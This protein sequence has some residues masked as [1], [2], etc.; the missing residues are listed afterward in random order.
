MPRTLIVIV[1]SALLAVTSIGSWPAAKADAAGVGST[2][3]LPNITRM[4]GGADGWQTPFIVQNVGS[5][6]TD[7]TMDFFAFSDGRLVKTRTIPAVMPGTSVFHDPNSDT[8][9]PQGGQFSVVVRSSSSPI[10]SVV[11]E[12]QNVT[13]TSRQEA[14]SYLGISSGSTRVFLPY[15]AKNAGGWLTT[16]IIQNLGVAPANVTAQFRSVDGTQT[17][18]VSR[19]IGPGRSQFVDPTVEPSV[20]AGVEYS[21]ALVSDQPIGVVV[22]AHNDAAG[23]VAPKGFSYN[24]V[25]APSGDNAFMPYVQ[26]NVNGGT[27][28]LAVQNAG[29]GPTT[30]Q[31]RF[32]LA[33][34]FATPIVVTG[35]QLA[36]GAMWVYDPATNA[37]IADGEYGVTVAGGL[38]AVVGA[39]FSATSAAGTTSTDVRSAKLYFPNVTKTLGGANGWTTPL[40][41]QSTGAH[42]ATLKWYRFSDGSLAYSQTLIFNEYAQTFRIDPRQIPDLPDNSQYAVVATAGLGGYG[43]I[44][45]LVT[46]MN[47]SGGDGWMTYEGVQQPAANP[48]GTPGCTPAS[49]PSGTTFSCAFYGFAPGSTVTSIVVSN[50]AGA[51]GSGSPTFHIVGVD[52]SLL[53]P[54]R[55]LN[56]GSRTMTVTVG[57]QTQSANIIVF[58]PSF[59]MVF[60]E[61]KFGAVTINTLPGIACSLTVQL[62]NGQ[63]L[64]DDAGTSTRITNPQ[65]NVAWVYTKPANTTGTGMNVVD[66]TSGAESPER[67][68]TFTAP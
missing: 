19:V 35:P 20:A 12:H 60:S 15:A 2:I 52:G 11:N 56:T 1:L 33:A 25:A 29:S 9:L 49:G 3:Y 14:L 8:E 43:G 38:W 68:A 53:V 62:P 23:T 28:R 34:Q 5:V 10:V 22:N 37:T 46:E 45:G 21:V 58:D 64:S 40:A 55:A 66:C 61:S 59:A 31:L 41:I 18:S 39:T 44:T 54:F 50:P 36:P 51:A 13:N 27:T 65:G 4:L 30:P 32:R 24:G 42:S 7:V 63:I 67:S 16:F 47:L 26:K 48:F 17:P 57:T 6:A